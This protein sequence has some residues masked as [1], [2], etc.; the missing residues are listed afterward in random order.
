VCVYAVATPQSKAIAGPCDHE[1]EM[2]FLSPKQLLGSPAWI[3]DSPSV[4]SRIDIP[5]R[6][7]KLMPLHH[8]LIDLQYI[9]PDFRGC[10]MDQS[11]GDFRIEGRDEQ[12]M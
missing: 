12:N 9:I 3:Y 8:E 2:N 1:Q 5:L 10:G 7:D 4:R 11:A 6:A